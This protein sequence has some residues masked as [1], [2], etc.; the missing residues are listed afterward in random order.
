M[1][2]IDSHCHLYEVAEKLN[3]DVE[4]V[5]KKAEEH[6]VKYILTV[7]TN[8]NDIDTS[9]NMAKT[10]DNVF[11]AVGIHPEH[12]AEQYDINVIKSYASHPKV[13]AIGEI[14]LDFFYNTVE[15]N[16]QIAVFEKMLNIAP[17]LPRVIHARD[18]M[19]DILDII[20]NN[21][22]VHGVFH[23]Y[24]DSLENA[25][26]VLDLGFY[27]SFS[28]IATFKK[29]DALRE[30]VRYVP[31]DRILVETDAPFLAPEP[32]RGQVNQPTYAKQISI[33]LASER[34]T[35][36]QKFAEQTTKNF[37]KCFAKA[38]L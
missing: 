5:I 10:Y 7:S 2:L 37:V 27:I 9:V 29:A 1:V 25:K 24:T 35:P 36:I 38:T 3:T 12:A 21:K 33:I 32:F 14:G 22:N 15:R 13:V 28:G 19:P 8:R 23:C 18:C 20:K 17:E 4:D 6:D 30:V 26:H 11:C 16:V 34:N 31:D